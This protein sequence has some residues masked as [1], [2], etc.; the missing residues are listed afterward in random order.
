MRIR[1]NNNFEDVQRAIRRFRE[2]GGDELAQEMSYEAM[3]VVERRARTPGKYFNDRTGA[4]RSSIKA[5]RTTDN[6]GATIS[7]GGSNR[8]NHG[9]FVEIGT[10][11]MKARAPLRR[12]FYDTIPAQVRAIK[13]AGGKVLRAW[14]RRI[15]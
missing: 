15:R 11:F 5:R 6:P 13:E 14:E 8:T 7:I 4:A 2:V 9:V 12:A 10:R 1:V 3:K